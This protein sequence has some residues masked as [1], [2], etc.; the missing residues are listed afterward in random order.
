MRVARSLALAAGFLL[1]AAPHAFADV[2]LF[3]GSTTTPTARQARGVAIGGGI[4]A[5]GFEFEYSDTREDPA[6][7]APSLRTGMGNILLQ[8]PIAIAGFQPYF[9]TGAGAY[10]ESLNGESETQ[11]GGNA[12][13]GVKVRLA[14][15]L[16]ARFDYRVFRL[17]G[18]PLHDV[19][20]RLYVGANLAF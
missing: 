3:V 19:V 20:H 12:G 4:L 6:D 10:R 16:R 18:E 1:A 17:R 13:G 5:L 9:T 8:T 2:T 14:G 11:L 7:A 15:P